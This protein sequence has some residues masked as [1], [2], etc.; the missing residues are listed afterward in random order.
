[1]KISSP[2][3][4]LIPELWLEQLKFNVGSSDLSIAHSSCKFIGLSQSDGQEK[5]E[6]GDG[7]GWSFTCESMFDIGELISSCS[8]LGMRRLLQGFIQWN[9]ASW[10]YPEGESET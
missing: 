9:I 6:N 10:R 2:V 1:M 4:E 7:R 3:T 8:K 5:E